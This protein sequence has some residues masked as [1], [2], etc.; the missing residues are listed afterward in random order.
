[1]LLLILLS[2]ILPST[3]LRGYDQIVLPTVINGQSVVT[4][5]PP[6]TIV[7]DIATFQFVQPSVTITPSNVT[8]PLAISSASADSYAYP[9]VYNDL[10]AATSD[11]NDV[12]GLTW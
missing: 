6:S 3:S 11:F 12:F 10:K 1:M 4:T 8:I 2:F 7:G 9:D 5:P